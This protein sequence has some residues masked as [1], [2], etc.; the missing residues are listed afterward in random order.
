MIQ[1]NILLFLSSLIIFATISFA[2]AQDKP[3]LNIDSII[4]I[5]SEQMRDDINYFKVIPQVKENQTPEESVTLELFVGLYDESESSKAS[6]DAIR[7]LMVDDNK[8]SKTSHSEV[9]AV[10]P[11]GMNP[12]Y[13]GD[14]KL[15]ID[16][17]GFKDSEMKFET[18]P[19]YTFFNPHQREPSSFSAKR[20]A[21]IVSK[22]TLATGASYYALTVT[23]GLAPGI[24]LAVGV[25]PGI[26]STALTVYN[27]K[28][29]RFLTNGSWAKWLLSNESRF[30]K[31]IR[32]GL[33]LT[34]LNFE[35]QLLKNETFLMKMKPELY[36]NNREL[37]QK[38][39]KDLTTK[40]INEK[41]ESLVS[42][43]KKLG[44]TDEYLK[45][46]ATEVGFT[47][48]VIKIPQASVG[49]GVTAASTVLGETAGVLQHSALGMLAQGPGDLA[50]QNR[51][52][53]KIADLRKAIK[54]KT[55]KVT[56]KKELLHYKKL[57][58]LTKEQIA[59]TDKIIKKG[60]FIIDDIDNL[61]SQ[62]KKFTNPSSSYSISKASHRA[63]RR[64]EMWTISRASTL[65]IASMTGM[66]LKVAQVPI[67]PEMI[68]ISIGTG[69]GIYMAQVKGW[70][71]KEKIQ[72]LF[73]KRFINDMKKT[74]LFSIDGLVTRFCMKKYT[75][76]HLPRY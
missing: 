5:E 49:V 70:V 2:S 32:K 12:K 36:A 16:K 1:K 60:S 66:I 56:T 10:A 25:W 38:K 37:F 18:I 28:F 13:E 35:K 61:R 46:Y 27:G 59:N 30:A 52:N 67:I 53:Q 72:Y 64:V 41:S 68:L 76:K 69:G 43:A 45:W 75:M 39:V 29:G 19:K 24:A 26:A 4:D 71:S 44:A 54:S 74:N 9:W 42:I 33:G 58:L 23:N 51:K 34:P 22:F 17:L 65:S 50:I 3:Y 21:W 62:L 11:E 55:V 7:E 73:S 6:L 14:F 15:I 8:T 47:G 40:M 20:M 31:T 63:L 57:G 48:V